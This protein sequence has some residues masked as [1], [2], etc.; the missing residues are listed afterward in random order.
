MKRRIFNKQVIKATAF[1]AISPSLYSFANKSSYVRL[2]GPVFEK[3]DSPDSWISALKRQ[4]YRAAYCPL[5]PGASSD[6]IKAYEQAAKKA[7]IVISEVGVWINLI[8][9]DMNLRSDAIEKTKKALQLADAIGANCCVN[10][11]GS[12]NPKQWAGPHKDN[13]SQETFDEIVQTAREII[14]DV[15]PT[16]TYFALE[17][18][19]WA[20]PD[21]ADNY[22]RLI[23]AI[24]RK[25]FGV[26][27]DPMNLIVSPQLFY[28]SGAMIKDCFNKL[29]PHIRSCHGKDIVLR[30]D[31]Y[32]PQLTECRPG[33]GF[34]DYGVFLK[35]LSKL[36]DIPL[37]MEHLTTQEEY[38]LAAKYIRS[39]GKEEGIEL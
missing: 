20:Y 33:L 31:I 18:M 22:V 12:K 1:T 16:R 17:P 2:G 37:M 30:E 21:S 6:E 25:Q 24:D 9:P 39:V 7:D 32:T 34:L 38:S 5:Q 29:G 26:H 8:S 23:K 11:S 14:D 15:A 4:Q 36:K 35:E 10:V 28:N 27:L 13:L 19:P 3:I